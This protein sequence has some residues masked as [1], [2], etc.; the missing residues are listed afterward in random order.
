[1]VIFLVSLPLF[2]AFVVKSPPGKLHRLNQIG[3]AVQVIYWFVATEL[4]QYER[5][6]TTEYATENGEE[7]TTETQRQGDKVRSW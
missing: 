2:A 3:S 7:F 5:L 6:A 1:M 4:N